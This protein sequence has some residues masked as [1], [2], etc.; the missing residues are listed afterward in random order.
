MEK[1]RIGILGGTFNPIHIG[2]LIMAQSAYESFSLDEVWI[3]P[4]GDPAHKQNQDVLDKELR[5]KM[6][7]LAIEDHPCFSLSRCEVDASGI[8][9]TA[10]TLE[11]LSKEH[12]DHEYYFILGADSLFDFDK[13]REPKRICSYGKILAATRNHKEWQDLEQR[14]EELSRKL[15]GEF[16]L[17][18]N[19][20]LEISSGDI[21][22]RVRAG[23]SIRYLVP[24]KVEA[25]I[26][27]HQIYI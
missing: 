14:A 21:R 25:Y 11:R 7:E 24:E 16:Y 19:P 20:T 1:K 17:L 27:G 9:Y 18:E 23:Q 26:L 4:A 15:G 2:H 12:P 8:T 22:K 6:V 3:M 10:E 5:V 13:W